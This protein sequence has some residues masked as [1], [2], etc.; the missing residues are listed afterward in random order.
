MRV[1]LVR[2]GRAGGEAVS[3]KRE[4]RSTKEKRYSDFSSSLLLAVFLSVLAITSGREDLSSS[5]F[6]LG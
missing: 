2:R 1:G 4:L 6:L 3:E 5:P